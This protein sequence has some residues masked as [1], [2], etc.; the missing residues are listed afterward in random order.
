MN[1]FLD[2]NICIYYMKNKSQK[3]ND[4]LENTITNKIKLPSMVVAELFYGASKSKWAQANFNH[5]RAFVSIY[6]IIPFEEEAAYRY[7]TIRA[8]LEEKGQ[9]IG[10]NDMIIAATVLSRDGVLVTNNAG[11]FSRVKNLVVEDWTI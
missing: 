5:L 4:R 9:I 6:E 8:Y 2:S 3:L 1:Y 7:G 11:E 10:N